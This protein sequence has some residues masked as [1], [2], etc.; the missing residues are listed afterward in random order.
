MIFHIYMNRQ[1]LARTDSKEKHYKIDKSLFSF[2][3]FI[4]LISH[5]ELCT[6]NGRPHTD[7]GPCSYNVSKSTE[8]PL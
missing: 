5:T 2:R 4:F 8:Q 7:G 1:K 3:S 6:L